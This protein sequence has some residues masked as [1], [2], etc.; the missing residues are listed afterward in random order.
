M[1][2]FHVEK[3]YREWEFE[4]KNDICNSIVSAVRHLFSSEYEKATHERGKSKEKTGAKNIGHKYFIPIVPCIPVVCA[5]FNIRSQIDCLPFIVFSAIE[6]SHSSPS[7]V[8]RKHWSLFILFT[9][10]FCDIKTGAP[11]L[12]SLHLCLSYSHQLY[13]SKTFK[14]ISSKT[15]YTKPKTCN[16]P[17]AQT[18]NFPSFFFSRRC[19]TRISSQR[20]APT[21]RPP[22]RRTNSSRIHIIQSIPNDFIQSVFGIHPDINSYCV[23]I[24]IKWL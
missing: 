5:S 11:L 20:F 22:E 24:K 15:L 17:F 14:R 19:E 9:R 1:K 2:Q 3:N 16:F 4:K 10:M 6:S 21:T 8:Y 18:L 13:N 12:F 7:S 23:C